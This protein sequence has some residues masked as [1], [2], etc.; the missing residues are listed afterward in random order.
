MRPGYPILINRFWPEE[1]FIAQ[2]ALIQK[3]LWQHLVFTHGKSMAGWQRQNIVGGPGDFE[4][5][6]KLRIAC[7]CL[8]CIVKT[9]FLIGITGGSASGKTHFL[10]KLS[11]HFKDGD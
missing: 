8:F 10:N 11:S 2:S 7:K 6:V 5:L 9:P 1:I 3:L 4:H